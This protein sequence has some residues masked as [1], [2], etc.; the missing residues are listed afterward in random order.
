MFD[1]DIGKIALFAVVAL[2]VIGPKDLPMALRLLGQTARRLRQLKTKLQGDFT[3][4]LEELE[5]VGGELKSVGDILRTDI[6]YNPATAM[7]SRAA[8]TNEPAGTKAIARSHSDD[9]AAPIYASPEMGLYFE[10]LSE[11]KSAARTPEEEIP[12]PA[13]A[14]PQIAAS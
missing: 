7:R 9:A 10:A 13:D 4:G 1:I 2:I 14:Q 5:G 11:L 12:P 8:Q 6:S 3:K